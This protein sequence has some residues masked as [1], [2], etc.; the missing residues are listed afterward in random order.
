MEKAL[1][2][3]GVVLSVFALLFWL[4]MLF[5]AYFLGGSPGPGLE[6]SVPLM[7]AGVIAFGWL[8]SVL[9]FINGINSLKRKQARKALS[10]CAA[11]LGACGSIPFFMMDLTLVGFIALTLGILPPLFSSVRIA[12]KKG[13][14]KK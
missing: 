13:G 4:I 2:L 8:G 5:Y 10:I 6:R 14:T 11:L 9:A 12:E 1:R 7:Y 3:I